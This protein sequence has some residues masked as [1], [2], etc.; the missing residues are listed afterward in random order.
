V[1]SIDGTV[2]MTLN[3]IYKYSGQNKVILYI[4]LSIAVRLKT[5][6]VVVSIPGLQSASSISWTLSQS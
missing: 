2:I 5:Q 3:R 4:T 6:N 1:C